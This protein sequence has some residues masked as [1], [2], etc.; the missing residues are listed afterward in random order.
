MIYQPEDPSQIYFTSR[1]DLVAEE[2]LVL[3]VDEVVKR[4]DLREL[5]GRY[6]ERGAAFYDPG[7]Q[8]RVLFYAYCD[9]VRSCREIEK[10][11]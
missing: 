7:M 8:L 9:G 2:P 5:Y 4:L 10:R 6:C 11:V 1:K 3:W